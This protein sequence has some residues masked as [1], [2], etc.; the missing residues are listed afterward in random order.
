MIRGTTSLGSELHHL[1]ILHIA[2]STAKAA[3]RHMRANKCGSKHAYRAINT[4][5][6]IFSNLSLFLNFTFLFCSVQPL[7]LE[8]PHRE[9]LR[10]GAVLQAV[11]L[12][13]H[14][15]ALLVAHQEV[16]PAAP[17]VVPRAAAEAPR[18]AALRLPHQDL[19]RLQA[20]HHEFLPEPILEVRLGHKVL[21]EAQEEAHHHA[22]HPEEHQEG[23]PRG[24][25]LPEVALPL[26]QPRH[27]AHRRHQQVLP[28]KQ[29]PHL[30]RL[31]HRSLED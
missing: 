27:R 5:K 21:Q 13:A 11:L 9:G 28:C 17:R 12:V 29:L 19:A 30:V 14:H 7:L 2:L 15:E 16:P 1:P 31:H 4:R 3:Y 23:Q 10:R 22:A 18:R 24:A 26:Q 8:A 6:H 20:R 25:S